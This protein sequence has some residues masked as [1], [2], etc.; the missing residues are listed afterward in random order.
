MEMTNNFVSK[1]SDSA[2]LNTGEHTEH[3][4]AMFA[5]FSRLLT[6]VVE[7]GRLGDE[8]KTR[9]A[10][11]ELRM[12]WSF[13]PE[14][15]SNFPQ[16]NY[17]QKHH[18][19]M[20]LIS[21]VNSLLPFVFRWMKRFESLVDNSDFRSSELGLQYI[22]DSRL[23]ARWNWDRDILVLFGRNKRKL[24]K[25]L[26]A[27]GQ[28]R[29]VI[30]CG[31]LTKR[32]LEAYENLLTGFNLNLPRD[33]IVLEAPES[34]RQSA[35]IPKIV[36]ALSRGL[37][38]NHLNNNT[39][40]YFGGINDTQRINNL[41]FLDRIQP[42]EMLR[43]QI[44]GKN[45]VIVSPGP[46]LEKNIE[47]LCSDN[48]KIIIFAV[49]QSIPALLKHGINPDYV[50]VSDPQD[51]SAI[52]DGLDCTNISAILADTAHQ[53]FSEK[54]FKN[55][56]L[57][58]S[59]FTPRE[60]KNIFK[61]QDQ[62]VFGASVSV[63][64]FK[65]A[66]NLGARNVALIG[67]DL[68]YGNKNYYVGDGFLPYDVDSPEY[69]NKA[70]TKYVLPIK[71]LELPGYYGG[72]VGTRPDY[73]SYHNAFVEFA[74][75]IKN[76]ALDV[77]IFNCTE[78]GAFIKGFKHVP[79]LNF[80]NNISISSCS[81]TNNKMSVNIV[82]S[83][84]ALVKKYLLALKAKCRAVDK[85]TREGIL[86]L[87]GEIDPIKLQKNSEDLQKAICNFEEL[88]NMSAQYLVKI[89]KRLLRNK[90]IQGDSKISYQ[91]YEKINKDCKKLDKICDHV[92][93]FFSRA[94]QLDEV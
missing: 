56:Y 8:T 25:L 32:A 92:L 74:R 47:L 50:L 91:L 1:V 93:E 87:S 84:T 49:A 86:L 21:R 27:R 94:L 9:H 51:Y 77:E 71:T 16:D 61:V 82:H 40:A 52:I 65:L 7:Y 38:I 26:A 88:G 35:E 2:S 36:A 11:D 14:D 20:S 29:I 30:I 37:G 34:D 46:S 60:F 22:I 72:F 66:I 43:P 76:E 69:L 19:L 42:V 44:R 54:P 81:E 4:L 59:Q 39:L 23:P 85:L 41:K 80:L 28:K 13:L 33:I 58:F 55:L 57:Y 24:A 90:I 3:F 78:G 48:N 31:K 15:L 45:V 75:Q 17:T 63:F 10:I 6:N 83:R 68:S 5:Q 53:G 62:D 67:Q 64:A 70:T 73:W 12:V 18:E 89:E 79:F